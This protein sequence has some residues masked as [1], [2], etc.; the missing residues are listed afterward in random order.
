[1]IISGLGLVTSLEKII[2]ENS[3]SNFFLDEV[4]VGVEGIPTKS[5][6][7]FSKLVPQN[8]FFWIACQSHHPPSQRHLKGVTKL[9]FIPRDNMA[10]LGQY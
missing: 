10:T 5:L 3:N 9:S 7:D 6:N 8:V 2:K 1:M 4:P